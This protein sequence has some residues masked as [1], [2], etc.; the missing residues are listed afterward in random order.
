MSGG[1][2]DLSGYNDVPSRIREFRD[3]Y[4]DGSLRAANPREPF[5]IVTVGDKTFV[6]YTAE[7]YRTPDDL[8]PG[9]GCAWEQVPG[10]TPYTRDSELQNAETSAWGRAIIAV[11]AAD[12]QRGIASMEDVRNRQAEQALPATPPVDP[13]L[14]AAR[15]AITDACAEAGVAPADAAERFLLG[16]G[17]PAAAATAEE[18]H[19]FARSL[20][21]APTLPLPDPKPEQARLLYEKAKTGGISVASAILQAKKLSVLDTDVEGQ[22]LEDALGGLVPPNHGTGDAA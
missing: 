15:Q 17:K 22:R 21:A 11:G 9:I 4:P 10:R 5:S 16:Y 12:A 3:K 18:M 19:E 7:A 6:A 2:F 14:A 20:L 1:D 13:A 8:A